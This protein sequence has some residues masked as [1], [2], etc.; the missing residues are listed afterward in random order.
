MSASTKT[1]HSQK[2]NKQIRKKRH[3]REDTDTERPP[4]DEEK[5]LNVYSSKSRN[6]KDYQQTTK[7]QKQVRKDSPT[8]FRENTALPKS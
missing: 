5:R 7:S 8:G 1:Q 3:P 4:C 6:I 2:H